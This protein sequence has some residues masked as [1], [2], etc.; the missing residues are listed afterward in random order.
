MVDY[1]PHLVDSYLVELLYDFSEIRSPTSQYIPTN[2]LAD[3]VLL[4]FRMSLSSR[5]SPRM[6]EGTLR[7]QVF[8]KKL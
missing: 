8:T 1:K 3:Y 5:R 7:P 2:S 4:R 6:V